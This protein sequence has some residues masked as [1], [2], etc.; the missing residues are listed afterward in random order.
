[1]ERKQRPAVHFS[2]EFIPNFHPPKR[3]FPI[4]IT[5]NDSISPVRTYKPLP[6]YPR[7]RQNRNTLPLITKH[8][9]SKLSKN[10]TNLSTVSNYSLPE[11]RLE[12][13]DFPKSGSLKSLGKHFRAKSLLCTGYIPEAAPYRLVVP[14]VTESTNPRVQL[15]PEEFPRHRIPVEFGLFRNVRKYARMRGLAACGATF[16]VLP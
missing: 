4:E 7:I 5:F 1:M 12:T 16:P 9:Y 8:K 13:K 2:T 6:Q 11:R 14:E 10:K 15:F 3:L